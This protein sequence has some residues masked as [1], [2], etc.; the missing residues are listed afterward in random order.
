[1]KALTAD[2][3]NRPKVFLRRSTA[4]VLGAS[5]LLLSSCTS[6]DKQGT[7]LV[8]KLAAPIAGAAPLDPLITPGESN[9]HYA[10]ALV[11]D[12][13]MK[14]SLFL[15]HMSV[16]QRS[17]SFILDVA[18][19]IASTVGSAVSPIAVAHIFSAVAAVST[20]TK[21]AL[22]SDIFQQETA[23]LIVQ[24]IDQTYFVEMKQYVD[25]FKEADPLEEY[26]KIALIHKDCSLDAAVAK[27]GVKPTTPTP[28]KAVKTD[29]IKV[30]DKFQVGN[31]IVYVAQSA[32]TKPD[33][34]VSVNVVDS[35]GHEGHLK[36]PTKILLQFEKSP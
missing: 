7:P 25:N 18:A 27:L 23:P 15:T 12:S 17:D 31:G 21:T 34:D 8:D 6:K 30:G 1:M 13:V 32:S 24:A 36:I 28:A 2:H 19:L 10:F 4:L 3:V 11:Q 16:T 29:S 14:C 22:D 5:F 33:E 35:K 9:T 20:G 26:V